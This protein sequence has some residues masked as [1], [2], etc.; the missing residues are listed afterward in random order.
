[1]KK[2]RFATSS[3]ALL[4][5]ALAGPAE[6][7]E[8]QV[9]L[10]PGCDAPLEYF[11]SGEEAF[12]IHPPGA[13]SSEAYLINL[14][15]IAFLSSYIHRFEE[16]LPYFVE[17]SAP[18]WCDRPRPF[19]GMRHVTGVVRRRRDLTQTFDTIK[20]DHEGGVGVRLSSRASPEHELS[21][22]FVTPSLLAPRE[23]EPSSP[24]IVVPVS[25]E[26]IVEMLMRG[27]FDASWSRSFGLDVARDIAGD[28][29]SDPCPCAKERYHV[30]VVHD[31][32]KSQRLTPPPSLAELEVF[33]RDHA[34]RVE[35]LFL[36]PTSSPRTRCA[37]RGPS[38]GRLEI[39][40]E[41]LVGSARASGFRLSSCETCVY[42]EEPME[43]RRKKMSRSTDIYCER[44]RMILAII[45]G[46]DCEGY[47]ESRYEEELREVGRWPI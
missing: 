20:L 34:D 10:C 43:W 40:H 14:A 24:G 27:R 26:G 46:H 30:L 4:L 1:M 9:P 44:Y 38:D 12:F 21:I 13:C 25:G 5:D 18:T 8:A 22:D 42:C 33:A 47:V 37:A 23:L 15:W 39:I 6:G 35:A 19:L 7:E 11:S 28:E 2:R 31:G 17:T 32:E 16:G 36:E 3:S 45:H 29:S 41:G